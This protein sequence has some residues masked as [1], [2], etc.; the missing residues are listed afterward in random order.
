MLRLISEGTC[1]GLPPAHRSYRMMSGEV[2][3][4]EETRIPDVP[5]ERA[6]QPETAVTAADLRRFSLTVRDLNDPE[7]MN[8]AWSS[9]TSD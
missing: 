8:R 1:D 9:K 3:M 7:V 2:H 4:I 6:E 5:E